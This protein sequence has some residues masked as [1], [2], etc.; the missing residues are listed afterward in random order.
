[1]LD[2]LAPVR[3][4]H[5]WQGSPRYAAELAGRLAVPVTSMLQCSDPDV[6]F[7]APPASPDEVHELLFVGNSRG[8]RRW[9]L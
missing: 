7:P 9:V 1:M 5:A 3:H 2:I 4:V 8:E 6:F